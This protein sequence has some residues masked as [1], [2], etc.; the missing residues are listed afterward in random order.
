MGI[1]TECA[2]S[3]NEDQRETMIRNADTYVGVK[4]KMSL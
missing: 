2:F 1:E 4:M 3:D